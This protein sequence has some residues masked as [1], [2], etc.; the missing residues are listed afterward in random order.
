MSE[1]LVLAA[2]VSAEALTKKLKGRTIGVVADNLPPLDLDNLVAELAARVGKP[3]RLAILGAKKQ[4]LASNGTV[5]VT[6]SQTLA[7]TWRNDDEA[8]KGKRLVVLIMGAVSK[9]RSLQSALPDV[10]DED[11]RAVIKDRALALLDS[12]KRRAFWTYLEKASDIFTVGSLIDFVAACEKLASNS[13]KHDLADFEAQFLWMLGVIPHAKILDVEGEKKVAR[14]V[15]QNLDMVKRLKAMP[16]ADLRLVTAAMND[17]ADAAVKATAKALMVYSQSKRNADLEGIDFDRVTAILSPKKTKTKTDEDGPT[18]PKEKVLGDEAVVEDILNNSGENLDKIASAFDADDDDDDGNEEV[19]LGSRTLVKKTRVGTSQISIAVA[20]LITEERFGGIIHSD[21]AN[22]Y[23]ETL[24]MLEGGEATTTEFLPLQSAQGAIRWLIEKALSHYSPQSDVLSVWTGYVEAR[25]R[26]LK[27]KV[28]L[29]DHPLLS[30]IHDEQLLQDVEALVTAYGAMMDAMAQLRDVI[31]ARSPNAAKALMSKA[32]AL[33]V[34]YLKYAEN[35][36]VAV[37]GPTHPFHLWRWAQIARLLKANTKDFQDLGDDMVLRYVL[38]PPVSS[39]HVLLTD[40][41]AEDGQDRVYIGVGAIGSLPLY[42]PP[43]ARTTTRF[44]AD[45]I[46]DIAE[47]LVRS[48]PY[49]EFGFEVA[50]IDPPSVVEFV[51]AISTVNRGRNRNELIPIHIRVFRT[52]E[53]PAT[54]DEED[55]EMEEL[56]ASIHDSKGSFDAYPGIL[57]LAQITEALQNRSAHYVAVFEPGDA[58]S[59]K[60]GIDISP[61]LSPLIVPRHYNYDPLED[62]FT[63]TIVGSSTPFGAYYDLFRELLSLPQNNTIGRRSGANRWIPDL[64]KLGENTIW[65]SLID[66]GI[67][68]TLSIPKTIRLD[69][70]TTGNRDIHT[71]TSHPDII[72]RYVERVLV[73]GGLIPGAETEKR[74]LRFMRRLGGDTVPLVVGSASKA[75][76]VVFQQAR[77]LLAV[78]AVTAWY[79]REAPDSLVVSLDTEA[80]RAW[81]LGANEN[82]GRRGDLIVLRQTNQ[83]L[84]MDVVEVKAREDV[85]SVVQKVGTANTGY[86]LEGH[87]IGQIDNTISVLK[88]IL[89]TDGLSGV[90]KA[91]R[92]ILRDQLYMAVANAE[93]TADRRDRSVELLNEFFSQGAVTVNGRLFVVHVESHQT[94]HYPPK[95]QDHGLSADGNMVEV[96][97]IIESE[98]VK[99]LEPPPTPPDSPPAPQS[100]PPSASRATDFIKTSPQSAPTTMLASE[101]VA[102]S[103]PVQAAAAEVAEAKAAATPDGVCVLIGKD[104]AGNDITWDTR[105]NPNFGFLVTGDSGNGKSQTILAIIND[106]RKAG[107]PVLIFDFKNDY[108]ASD[109]TGPLNMKVYDVVQHGLPFNP[110]CLMPNEHGM[111]HP[112][113]QCHEF[114]SIIA[115]VEGLKEQQQ[116]RIVEAM[117]KAYEN[118]GLDPKAKVPLEQVKSEPVFDEVLDILR[119]NDEAVSKTVVYRLEKFSDLGLFPSKPVDLSFEELISDGVVMTLNDAANDKLMMVLAEILIVKLHAIIKRGEQ[120]RKLRRMLVMDEAW[121]ISRSER[122]VDLAREG[123]AFGVGMLIGT[124]NPGDMPENLRGCL[125]TQLYLNN[126]DVEKQKVIVRALCNTT[127]GPHAQKMLQTIANLGQFQGYL[128]SE[129]YKTGT[130]VNVIPHYQRG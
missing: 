4:L 72:S 116:A 80:S 76:Q 102:P 64:A 52:R 45:G 6:Y 114:A 83:G 95:P 85:Q 100:Q 108:S 115:R 67:E 28:D 62:Q 53:A 130:R 59:F 51:D 34:I 35:G 63:V 20:R 87:A 48:V 117:R 124:Q 78:L 43:D 112:I 42:G 39:P 3:Y 12:P 19:R 70:R 129:Q 88:R 120:P 105:L 56:A 73:A 57:N 14:L 68:P 89:P 104:P 29:V 118:H 61:T 103:D 99:D 109:F 113:R 21:V 106:L 82:D 65:F 9:L 86:R 11:L 8:K 75:G 1:A 22:D 33:D 31:R 15:R 77:G 23:I 46:G 90:D 17:A 121:R 44:R 32:L 16:K 96:Y 54:T 101:T 110:L 2:S 41:V 125:R 93:M 60:V 47:R 40:F 119:D 97:E 71:F 55:S 98:D 50:V 26:V 69:K 58:Q 127:S 5:E 84:A 36:T 122:L 128:I 49:A 66:Q 123:R 24:K 10:T 18:T 91:R 79:E 126:K 92:E 13:N 27:H 38:N 94:P 37:A 111:V 74:T 81:I 25:A 30:L 7:N 107:Y